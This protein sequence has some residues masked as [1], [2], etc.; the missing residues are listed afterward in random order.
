MQD[1]VTSR[2][3]GG[4][5]KDASIGFVVGMSVGFTFGFLMFLMNWLGV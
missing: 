5:M 1:G 2:D 3:F 4:K